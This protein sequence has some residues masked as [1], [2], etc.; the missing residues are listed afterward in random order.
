[1]TSAE[2]SN[3]PFVTGRVEQKLTGGL[4]V[5]HR[6]SATQVTVP[7][8]R[9]R[10]LDPRSSTAISNGAHYAELESLEV[11]RST[12]R[13]D[14]VGDRPFSVLVNRLGVDIVKP[15]SWVHAFVKRTV[16]KDLDDMDL[17]AEICASAHRVGRSP[18]EL[19]GGNGEG[20]RGGPGAI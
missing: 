7:V 10:R 20:E 1:M 13:V 9:K 19:D 4:R 15:D 6:L 11:A 8:A 16:G 17:V 12:P 14:E 18:R 5:V 2:S 3:A